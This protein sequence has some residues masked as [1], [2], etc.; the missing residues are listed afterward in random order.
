M[1]KVKAKKEEEDEEEEAIAARED[2]E[3]VESASQGAD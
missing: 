3:S 1:K 2:A